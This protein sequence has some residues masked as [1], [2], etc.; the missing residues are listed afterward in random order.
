MQIDSAVSDRPQPLLY[1]AIVSGPIISAID[2]M[3]IGVDLQTFR[4]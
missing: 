1:M 4:Q 2:N 3:D